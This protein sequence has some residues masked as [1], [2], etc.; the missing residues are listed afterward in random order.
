[1]FYQNTLF[2]SAF[3]GQGKEIKITSEKLLSCCKVKAGKKWMGSAGESR[4]ARL[5]AKSN[6]QLVG[7]PVS[8]PA[9]SDIC[10]NA[11]VRKPALQAKQIALAV[12]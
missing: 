5:V 4:L 2:Q 12:P 6:F 3:R 8:K 7:A 9:P 1:M 11:P 10:P